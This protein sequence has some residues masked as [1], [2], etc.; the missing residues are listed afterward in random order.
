MNKKLCTKLAVA[1]IK[2]NG[3]FYFPYLLTGIGTIMMFY[4]MC[5]LANN[6]GLSKMGS[7]GEQLKII[8]SMGIVVIGVFSAIFLFYTNSFLI[9][10]RK[11]E[12]GLYNILGMEKKHIGRVIGTENLI[13]AFVSLTLGLVCGVLFSKLMVLLLAKLLKFK[14]SFGF[15]V[16][17]Q[18]VIYT[19]I[20]FGLIFI[21]I[22]LNNIRQ[23]HLAQP[24]ELLR[25]GNVGEKEPKTKWI[26]AVL[27]IICLGTG[28]TIALI[29]ES[30]ISAL[31]MFLVAVLLVIAGTYLLFIAGSIAFLKI[32]R[33]NKKYYYK[34]KHFTSISGMLY[35]MKQNAVGLANICILSTMVLVML[36][37]TVSL[38]IGLGDALRSM[39][40]RNIAIY[41]TNISAND[42]DNLSKQIENTISDYGTKAINVI[43]YRSY[44]YS[45]SLNGNEF[46]VED[47]EVYV[48]SNSA[49][50][51]FIPLDE[52]NKIQNK[53]VELAE[54]E[55]L[56]YTPNG[57]Y[58]DTTILFNGLKYKIKDTL[59]SL[60]VEENATARLVDTYY[61]VIP[62]EKD[63]EKLYYTMVNESDN[64]NGLSYYYGFD[65][66]LDGADQ[67]I[68]ENKIDNMIMNLQ[69]IGY[70]TCYTESA[71][72]VRQTFLYSYGGLL[73]LGIF[74]GIL[75]MM[76]T[77]LIIYYKQ[78]SEGYDDKERF[79]IMQKVGMSKSE[80][81][82]SIS[83][84]ILTVFFL[85]VVVAAIHILAAFKMITKLLALLNLTNI[86]LF[87]GCTIV[88]VLI[89]GLIYA[90]V[91]VL[92]AK[93][94]YKIVRNL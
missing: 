90:L 71:E 86:S 92:T 8:L 83:S 78:I 54:N 50:V 47:N 70:E 4:I 10:R 13:V 7:G 80:V 58:T 26:L 57:K 85:P 18:S 44:F 76:A 17:W 20:V 77:V 81:K 52:Y 55:T 27:G 22:F 79:E 61:F 41:A 23:I 59:N 2:K 73:F 3:R 34:T 43:N 21:F 49:A 84:Q 38:Y 65:V 87:V 74:L 72:N 35:R 19:I 12:F 93:V 48:N 53:S 51:I 30:P 11:K 32:L 56:M 36:S 42:S 67:I 75:F 25:G 28:Y 14:I 45:L 68:L 88:T 5:F 9:K 46:T 40:P 24:I 63:I 33:K 60:N 91:Y 62:S 29:T 16:S 15:E 82:K 69:G 31:G 37:G 39:Y 1:N 66:N 94:Y 6:N 89:F 64:Y